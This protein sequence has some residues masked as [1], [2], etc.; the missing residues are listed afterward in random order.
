MIPVK[1]PP[2]SKK[3]PLAMGLLPVTSYTTPPVKQPPVCKLLPASSPKSQESDVGRVTST[4][5]NIGADFL[6]TILALEGNDTRTMRSILKALQELP[7]L[8]SSSRASAYEV[9]APADVTQVAHSQDGE[10]LLAHEQT[11][12]Q[13]FIH[14]A[15]IATH[16]KNQCD[17]GDAAYTII[18]DMYH[19][20][21]DLMAKEYNLHYREFG[22]TVN[23]LLADRSLAASISLADPSHKGFAQEV[24]EARWGLTRRVALCDSKKHADVERYAHT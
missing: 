2:P 14:F 12:L 16:I 21:E 24:Q 1:S 23:E 6:K 8:A 18:L 9:D 20:K 10:E 13:R 3:P 7:P 4:F 5:A 15:T 11:S 19:A 17:K 22:D